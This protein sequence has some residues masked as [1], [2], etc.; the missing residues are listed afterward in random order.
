MADTGFNGDPV[1]AE[2]LAVGYGPLSDGE[3]NAPPYWGETSWLV[4]GSGGQISTTGDT[5]RWLTAMRDGRILAPEWAE[6]YFGP[7]PGAARN[8]DAYGYEMFLYRAPMAE[9]YAVL[10]TNANDPGPDGEADTPFIRASRQVGDL[11]LEPYRPKF[12]LGVAMAPG[13]DG[14]VEVSR[15]VPGSAAERDGLLEGDLLVSANG[16]TFG[17]DPLVVIDPYLAS[18]DTILFGVRR[19]GEGLEIAVRPNPR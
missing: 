11:L 1:P 18:G 4:M 12:S 13:P 7:G 6:R 17:D 15:V 8:G 19:D 3:I 2:R 9:S 16:V 5:G 10:L 14:T